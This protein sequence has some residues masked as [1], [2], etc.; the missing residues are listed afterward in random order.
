M[1]ELRLGTTTASA[2]MGRIKERQACGI[3]LFV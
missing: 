3:S 1:S 2:V